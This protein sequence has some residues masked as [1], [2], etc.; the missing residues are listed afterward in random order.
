MA[1][2]VADLPKLKA[3]VETGDPPTVQPVA[4]RLPGAQARADVAGR[5]GPRRAACWRVRPGGAAGRAAV[6]E[7]LRRPR[8]RRPS[9]RA[10]GGVLEVVT[11]PVTIGAEPPEVLGTLSL[12]LRRSTTRCA[13]RA[14]GA[15]RRATWPSCSTAAS[16]PPRSAARASARSTRRCRRDGPDRVVLGGRASTWRCAR[17]LGARPR[18]RTAPGGRDPALAHGAA[19]LPAHVPHRPRSRPRW[20]R[21]RWPCC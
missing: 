12:G 15:D 3:A 14:Q 2:L 19:A 21:W 1:R 4:A 17:P 8:R 11:V 13:A 20:S 18:S 10:A 7:A 9:L 16:S 6:R 5:H